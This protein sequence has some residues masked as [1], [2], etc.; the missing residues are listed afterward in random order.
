M[1]TVNN[2][3]YVVNNAGERCVVHPLGSFLHNRWTLVLHRFSIF[4]FSIFFIFI[5]IFFILHRINKG[6]ASADGTNCTQDK[7]QAII[8]AATTRA[9]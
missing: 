1:I 3:R 6:Y 9:I 5:F 8:D 4:I 2:A 7:V